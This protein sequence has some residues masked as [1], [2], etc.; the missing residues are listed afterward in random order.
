MHHHL[1]INPSMN[2]PSNVALER[3]AATQRALEVR[4]RLL[5]SAAE[6]DGESSEEA[7]WMMSGWAESGSG[8]QQQEPQE[9]ADRREKASRPEEP[10]APISVW[11]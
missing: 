9:Q 6:L 2:L 1:S 11:A 4:K 5:R 10:D 3:T 7:D 8:R